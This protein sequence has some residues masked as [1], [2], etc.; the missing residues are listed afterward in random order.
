MELDRV[1]QCGIRLGE[2]ID[3][4]ENDGRIVSQSKWISLDDNLVSPL[5]FLGEREYQ[6]IKSYV[7][8]ADARIY[9]T[10]NGQFRCL[11][12]SKRH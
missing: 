2:A 12:P 8:I 3:I 7:A 1:E 9:E 10:W 5:S 11:Y 4:G 6:L